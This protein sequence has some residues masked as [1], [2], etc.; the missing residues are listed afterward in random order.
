M[1][2]RPN[3]CSPRPSLREALYVG[4]FLAWITALLAS[5]AGPVR[6]SPPVIPYGQFE[7]ASSAAMSP[8]PIRGR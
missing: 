4:A 1:S 8:P 5:E 7:A 2:R 3:R 6:L